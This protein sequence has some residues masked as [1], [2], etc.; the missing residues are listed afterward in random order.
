M[1]DN[2]NNTPSADD[3]LLGLTQAE[4]INFHEAKGISHAE[5][6]I[7]NLE[8]QTEFSARLILN[9]HKEAFGE[10]YAWAGKWRTT[11]LKVGIF[12]P[13]TFHSIPNLIYQYAD[14]VKFKSAKV[15]NENEL[16]DL[17]T[18]VHHR[19]VYIH[20][21]NNGNGRT[22]RLLMNFIAMVK[23]YKPIQLY[24]REGED[25]K[26]YIDAI[27]KGDKG[28]TESLKQLILKELQPFQ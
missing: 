3:N 18:Y 26:I 16:A 1:Q 10:L 14:E 25:R 11:D 23:G 2:T 12:V 21:F 27:R 20:P 24:H 9:I 17:L 15:M 28:N 8:E 4:E 5:L 22:A 7:L 13:P 6:F 19:F